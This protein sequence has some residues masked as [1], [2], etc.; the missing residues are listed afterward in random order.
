MTIIPARQQVQVLQC[1]NLIRL[2]FVVFI[3]LF[4]PLHSTHTPRINSISNMYN[5]YDMNGSHMKR[6]C[7]KRTDLDRLSHGGNDHVIFRPNK[8][9]RYIIILYYVW[10]S[11]GELRLEQNLCLRIR[12]QCVP[13]IELLKFKAKQLIVLNFCFTFWLNHEKYV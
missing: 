9:S 7:I 3:Y 1:E 12:H 6:D 4:P 13:I 10:T 5:D 11:C 2:Q 8:S